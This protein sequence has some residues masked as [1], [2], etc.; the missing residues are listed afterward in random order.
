MKPD[1]IM[2][3]T[4]PASSAH[5]DLQIQRGQDFIHVPLQPSHVAPAV[6]QNILQITP[7]ASSIGSQ[8]RPTH[9]RLN[10]INYS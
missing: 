4:P 1:N 8:E 2:H 3:M 5:S 10:I 7:P 6:A 9:E